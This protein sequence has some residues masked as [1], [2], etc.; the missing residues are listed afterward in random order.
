MVLDLENTQVEDGER[1]YIKQE[2]EI[3]LKVVKVTEGTTQNNN[4][5]IKV[6][7]Q[8]KAG[9]FAIDDFVVTPNALWK[10]KTLTKALKLPNVVDTNLFMDRYV[11]ATF[12]AKNTT[13]GGVIYE[14]KKYEASPLTNT[15]TPP[16]EY[17][18]QQNN[19]NQ[20]TQN[21]QQHNHQE[22]LP[23]VNDIDN[24]EIPV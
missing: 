18:H 17:V 24:D 16:V 6:H 2:G 7:F 15:Y 11:K 12:K 19:Q 13:N 10:I 1:V 22:P 5:Q 4:P 21:M 8:D 23:N 20:N 9:R 3:T 14:I